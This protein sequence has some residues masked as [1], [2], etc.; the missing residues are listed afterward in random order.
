MS[1]LNGVFLLDAPAS[2]LNN[3]GKI[4]GA[5]TDNTVGVKSISTREGS[6]PYVSAQAFRYWLRTTLENGPWGW[7]AAPIFRENKIA[8]TD[9]NPIRYWDDDLFGY[10]RAQSKKASAAESRKADAGRSEETLT[11]DTITR[12]SPFRV[13][14]LV[15]IAPVRLV[16]DFGVMSRH[17]GDPVPHEHQ[18]YRATLKGLLSLDLHAAGTFSYRKKTGYLNLD[19]ERKKEAQ[20]KGL[21]HLEEQKSYRLS[22]QQRLERISALLQGLAQLEGGAKLALHY[23]DVNPP[24]L[25]LAVTRG[26]NHIFARIIGR[27][28]LDRPTLQINALAEAMDVFADDL[29][30]PI[31]IGWAQGYLDEQRALLE[32]ELNEGGSLFAHH[33]HIQIAHPRQAIQAAISAL[34]QHPEWLA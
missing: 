14:T 29:L 26:G 12:V 24:L 6:Y 2:A 17:E 31:W 4:E 3:I 18:F 21:E 5:S 23:T 28:K 22:T 20:Q 27:D 32:T 13:S 8:Y 19:E 11:A 16:E 9:G 10:M 1:F 25:I 34:N 33:E 15:S 30:S 7:Q